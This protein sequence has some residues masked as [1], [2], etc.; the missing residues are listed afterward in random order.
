MAERFLY[1]L[2]SSKF[3]A[4]YD[5]RNIYLQLA[6]CAILYPIRNPDGI[7]PFMQRETYLTVSVTQLEAPH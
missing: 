5:S 4:Y 1:T 3:S 2:C 6:I 7:I